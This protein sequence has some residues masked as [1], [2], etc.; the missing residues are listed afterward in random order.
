LEVTGFAT[1]EEWRAK[2]VTP[3]CL[4]ENRLDKDGK[5]VEH[6]D[7]LQVIP[8]TSANQNRMF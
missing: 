5:V 3:T 6:W 4:L 2:P 8:E 7:V 1:V